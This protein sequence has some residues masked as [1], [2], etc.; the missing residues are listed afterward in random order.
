MEVVQR[1]VKKEIQAGWTRRR[2][3]TGVICHQRISPKTKD[4]IYTTLVRPSMTFGPE[5]ATLTKGQELE[6]EAA[7]L[8]ML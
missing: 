2:K 5:N 3:I 8:K 7:E 1:E 6:L 4:K